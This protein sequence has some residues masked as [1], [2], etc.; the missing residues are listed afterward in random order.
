MVVSDGMNM[1][2][3]SSNYGSPGLAKGKQGPSGPLGGLKE[4]LDGDGTQR[5]AVINR[6]PSQKL[7]VLIHRKNQALRKEK[8]MREKELLR[9]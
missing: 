2:L 6:V 4:Q 5:D 1:D 3:N 8:R 7:S 9:S